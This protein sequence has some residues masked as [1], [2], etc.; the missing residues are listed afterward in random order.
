MRSKHTRSEQVNRRARNE[1]REDESIQVHGPK[2][3][4]QTQHPETEDHCCV[5]FLSFSLIFKK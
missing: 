5:C 4:R 2:Q 1:R 3:L